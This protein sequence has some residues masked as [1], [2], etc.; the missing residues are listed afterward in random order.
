MPSDLEKTCWLSV[1]PLQRHKKFSNIASFTLTLWSR[2]WLLSSFKQQDCRGKYLD[3]IDTTSAF[4][5]N[6]SGKNSWRSFDCDWKFK[7]NIEYVYFTFFIS[8]LWILINYCKSNSDKSLWRSNFLPVGRDKHLMFKCLMFEW[9][10]LTSFILESVWILISFILKCF[11]TIVVV[12]VMLY[13]YVIHHYPF[14]AVAIDDSKHYLGLSEHTW[15]DKR[16]RSW[17]RHRKLTYFV[18]FWWIQKK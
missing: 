11:P 17:C 18:N 1:N 15:V 5:K 6:I 10:Q 14:V 16:R 3:T 9:Q 4:I 7:W 12:L 2:S 8:S 13:N